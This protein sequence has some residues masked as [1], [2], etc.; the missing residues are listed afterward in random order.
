MEITN[1][2]NPTAPLG[3]KAGS[4]NLPHLPEVPSPLPALPN[5]LLP[6]CVCLLAK[7]LRKRA[8]QPHLQPPQP[9]GEGV[10]RAGVSQP[11]WEPRECGSWRGA[12]CC[13]VLHPRSNCPHNWGLAITSLKYQMENSDDKVCHNVKNPLKRRDI[14]GATSQLAKLVGFVRGR[15]CGAAWWDGLP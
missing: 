12:Q 3:M 15:L 6:W 4:S 14:S 2:E 10:L 8:V 1:Q 5:L 13:T 7:V 11:G 9:C